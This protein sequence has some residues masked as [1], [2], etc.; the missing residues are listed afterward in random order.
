MFLLHF[1][2]CHTLMDVMNKN[3]ENHSPRPQSTQKLFIAVAPSVSVWTLTLSNKCVNNPLF[4][5]FSSLCPFEFN[6][7]WPKACVLWVFSGFLLIPFQRTHKNYMLRYLKSVYS[8]K[9]FE[10][11]HF[12]KHQHQMIYCHSFF[13]AAASMHDLIIVLCSHFSFPLCG[14]FYIVSVEGRKKAL[15]KSECWQEVG[16]MGGKSERRKMLNFE[17]Y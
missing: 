13:V 12:H 10:M 14:V 1:N 17:V 6:I 9:R 8:D 2:T 5:L 11:L 3:C 16:L 7:Y 4:D 15:F